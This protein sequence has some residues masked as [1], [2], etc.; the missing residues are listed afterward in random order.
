MSLP[1]LLDHPEWRSV[2]IFLGEMTDADL[3]VVAF[4]FERECAARNAVDGNAARLLFSSL[5]QQDLEHAGTLIER[6]V[7][8]RRREREACA[9][10]KREAGR[11]RRREVEPC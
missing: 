11:P 9:A 5:D 1:D 2:R 7:A 6:E 3:T 8:E 4:Q 10:A